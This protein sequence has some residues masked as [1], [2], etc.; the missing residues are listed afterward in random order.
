[1][2]NTADSVIF[3][4]LGEGYFGSSGWYLSRWQ[5]LMVLHKAAGVVGRG[6]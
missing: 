2:Y 6:K 3:F 5:N 1:M 4:I